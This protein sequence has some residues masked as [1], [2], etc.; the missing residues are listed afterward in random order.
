MENLNLLKILWIGCNKDVINYNWRI[1]QKG[2][3]DEFDTDRN[4]IINSIPKILQQIKNINDDKEII[5]TSLWR[6]WNTIS[7]FDYLLKPE[8]KNFE[9]FKSL[10]FYISI[11]RQM[12]LKKLLIN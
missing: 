9:E 11:I 12:N 3:F 10:G 2:V 1:N 6:K 8:A 5:N 7:K 4:K